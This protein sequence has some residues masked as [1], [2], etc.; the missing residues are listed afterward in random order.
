[1]SFR[2]SRS[3]RKTFELDYIKVVPDADISCKE[4]GTYVSTETALAFLAYER[5]FSFAH[6]AARQEIARVEGMKTTCKAFVV[7]KNSNNYGFIFRN[8]PLLHHTFGDA[9]RVATEK[10]AKDGGT[11]HVFACVGTVG[12]N[13]Q[14]ETHEQHSV[15]D[16]L[17]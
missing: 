14:K 15:H 1:M 13:H 9:L 4:D 2:R 16:G 8:K 12:T 17:Q 3:V 6:E 10:H 11:F 5:A 7:G